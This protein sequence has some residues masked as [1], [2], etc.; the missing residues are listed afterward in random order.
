MA[1]LDIRASEQDEITEIQFDRSGDRIVFNSLGITLNVCKDPGD[2]LVLYG[3]LDNFIKA[4]QKA[5]E[6]WGGK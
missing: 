2:L 4:C 1:T 5:K 6:L 3:E